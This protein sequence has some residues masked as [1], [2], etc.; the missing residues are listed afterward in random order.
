MA[1][2]ITQLPRI[3]ARIFS[4]CTKNVEDLVKNLAFWVL[5]FL[6]FANYI[7]FT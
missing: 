1:G 5:N 4:E 2:V 3:Q 6:P 7:M